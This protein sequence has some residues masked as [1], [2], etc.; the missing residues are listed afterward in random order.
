M[1]RQKYTLLFLCTGNYYRSRFAEILFNA[2]ADKL[3]LAWQ[4]ISRGLATE[5]ISHEDGPISTHTVTGL[6]QRG[7]SFGYD[8]RYPLQLE[9]ADLSQADRI[10]VLDEVEHRP[11]LEERY[12]EWADQVE[13]WNVPDRDQTPVGEALA[14]IEDNVLQLISEILESTVR[15]SGV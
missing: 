1:E 5:L 14:R 3:E 9:E 2:Q 12:P 4:A 11:Y 8:F 6:K 15:P 13:Y 7:I 10:V